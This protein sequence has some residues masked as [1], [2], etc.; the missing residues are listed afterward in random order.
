V[1]GALADYNRAIELAPAAPLAYLNRA[2]IWRGRG[3][4]AQA[5]ADYDQTIALNPRHADAYCNR[6]L[7]RLRQGEE[8]TAEK[9]FARC[10]ELNGELKASLE[11]RIRE[12]KAQMAAHTP[13]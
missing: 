11:Q 13:R 5:V 1:A 3:D 10:L 12:T 8:A 6:G 2:M 7:V 9:D 4:W